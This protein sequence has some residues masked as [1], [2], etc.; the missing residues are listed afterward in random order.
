MIISKELGLKGKICE[1]LDEN[2]KIL[3]KLEKLYAKEFG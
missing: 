2:L 3:N 1:I